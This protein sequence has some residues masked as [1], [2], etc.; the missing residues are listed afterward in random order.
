MLLH[1]GLVL[2]DWTS[3]PT[4]FCATWW[5]RSHDILH[6]LTKRISTY[7]ACQLL[8]TAWKIK[9]VSGGVSFMKATTTRRS[10]H[11]L[12]CT[13]VT[14][15]CTNARLRRQ[16]RRAFQRHFS[17]QSPDPAVDMRGRDFLQHRLVR[18]RGSLR[19]NPFRR[20]NVLAL[21]THAN[22]GWQ[23]AVLLRF[24]WRHRQGGRIRSSVLRRHRF[25]WIHM[26][27]M[28]S[29]LPM[30]KVAVLARLH[31]AVIRNKCGIFKR[32][33]LCFR[34]CGPAIRWA[35]WLLL[36]PVSMLRTVF[37]TRRQ[38][39]FRSP[40]RSAAAGRSA[41]HGGRVLPGFEL[42]QLAS[43]ISLGLTHR[44][45]G[46]ALPL[47]PVTTWSAVRLVPIRVTCHAWS[48]VTCDG[49]PHSFRCSCRCVG[50]LGRLPWN[51]QR[52][53]REV[54]KETGLDL[55]S[56]SPHQNW[57]K[58]FFFILLGEQG[59]QMWSRRKQNHSLCFKQDSK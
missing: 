41:R 27:S 42:S 30:P 2:S 39:P 51:G 7:G 34:A 3:S 54:R 40:L 59:A 10:N 17:C 13:R 48:D 8:C 15:G 53:S 31:T 58:Y 20:R 11:Q 56:R 29:P 5:Q 47:R 18:G 37:R 19:G 24:A 45:L 57:W 36:L 49:C 33:L 44:P 26:L 22:H 4:N 23:I 16:S 55:V 46:I 25:V 38:N 21:R 6:S 28:G 35:Q 43:E 14:L 50:L 52:F 32:V 1:T 9:A 12:G